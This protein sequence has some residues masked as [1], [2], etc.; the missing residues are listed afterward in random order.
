MAGKTGTDGARPEAEARKNRLKAA[1]KSNITKRKAQARA[2][3]ATA[4][5]NTGDQA[6]RD[7]GAE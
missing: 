3:A 6:G 4:E 7:K 1:L 2:R 5:T